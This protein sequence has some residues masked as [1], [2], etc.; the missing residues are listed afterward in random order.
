MSEGGPERAR[1]EWWSTRTHF[2]PNEFLDLW[3]LRPF[4]KKINLM[5]FGLVIRLF[6]LL[7]FLEF[8]L[9]FLSDLQNIS[10]ISF[11]RPLDILPK[12]TKP[13][14]DSYIPIWPTVTKLFIFENYLRSF[15]TFP[16][17]AKLIKLADWIWPIVSKKK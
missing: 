9:F 11:I 5:I 13:I 17:R 7:W 14:S 15:L 3:A 10:I 4:E 8:Y 2:R 6:S 1:R 12:L 16:N